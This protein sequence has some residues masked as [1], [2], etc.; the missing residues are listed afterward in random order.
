MCACSAPVVLGGARKGWFRA[1]KTKF[2]MLRADK[3]TFGVLVLLLLWVEWASLNHHWP[4]DHKIHQSS[5]L[6]KNY[7]FSSTKEDASKEISWL[8]LRKVNCYNF[9]GVWVYLR[10]GVICKWCTPQN[11]AAPVREKNL[12]GGLGRIMTWVWP[13]QRAFQAEW[14]DVNVTAGNEGT[15]HSPLPKG[16]S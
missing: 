11:T 5:D 13:F 6:C 9:W 10:L 16:C 1:W 12:G 3:W 8:C 14:M 7:S 15:H 2:L 4:K